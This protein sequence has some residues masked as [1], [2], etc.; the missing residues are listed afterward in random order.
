MTR[1]PKSGKGRKWTIKELEAIPSSWKGDSLSDGD[2]LTGTVRA[3]ADSTISIHFKSAFKWEGKVA[4]QYCGTW[5]SS[6]LESIRAERDQARNLVRQGIDPRAQRKAARIENQAKVE[7]IIADKVKQ[8]AA[9]STFQQMFDAWLADGVNRK[10]G[11]AELRRSFEKDVLPFLGKLPVRDITEHHLR[12]T[13][14]TMVQRE[15]NRMAVRVYNDLVQLFNWAEKRQPWRGLMLEG[16]PADL[17]EIDKLLPNEYD[18][19]GER[20]RTLSFDELREL[21]SIFERM[22]TEYDSAA[23]KRSTVRPLRRESQAALWIS[24]GT[25]CRIGELL[26]AEWAHVDLEKGE[27]F[28][29]KANVKGTTGKKQDQLV[30]LSAFALRQFKSLHERTGTTSWCF[31]AK[32]NESH[33][34]VKTVSKQVGDRQSQFK[35][36]KPLKNRRHDDTLVLANGKNGEWTPH[37]LRRTAATMMQ[38]LRISLD[39]I[40][41][42]QNH[43]MKG[44]RVRRHYLHHNYAD[45][46]KQAWQMLGEHLDKVFGMN[47]CALLA[48]NKPQQAT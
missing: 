7:A 32:N 34:C 43:V 13:L 10:D 15:V 47:N 18:M 40:D 2:G 20:E 1:Y 22:Q 17:I 3:T 27:W 48:A 44:G 33:V 21:R 19:D 23:N 8:D 11:N 5:P 24:L 9:N 12:N 42:C 37:D 16:N 30:F 41:R 31:P 38:S 28:I 14:R 35:N 29:P 6:S 45:E 4:W 25:T 46:K 36:R 26:M 39:V